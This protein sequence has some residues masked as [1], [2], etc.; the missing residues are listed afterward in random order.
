MI[1]SIILGL[2]TLVAI[3]IFVNRVWQLWLLLNLGQGTLPTNHLSERIKSVMINV[4]GQKSVVK[5]KSG[6]GHFFIFWGFIIVTFG[7]IE[8]FIAGF[9]PGFTFAFLGPVYPFMNFAQD[10]MAFTVL[11]AIAV[12]LYRRIVIQ[13]MRLEAPPAHKR[14]A[15]II[16]GMIALLLIC[17]YGMRIIDQTKPGFMPVASFLRSLVG[18]TLD[19][20]YPVFDWLHNLTVL[21]FLAFVPYSKHLH[22]LGA[23]PNIFF[24][25]NGKPSR[26]AKLDL[27]GENSESFGIGKISDYTKKDLLDLYAC[28]ECGR[29]QESCPAYFTAKPLSP[30]EV[31]QDLKAHLVTD[32]PALIKDPK[33]E[34]KTKLFANVITHDVLWACTTCRACE[35]VCPVFISPMGKLIGIRQNR[36]LMEGDF[37]EEAQVAMKNMENQSNPWGLP[38]DDRAKWAEGLPVKTLAEKADVEYLYYVGCSGAYDERNIQV[39]KAVSGLL[40]RAGVSWAILGKEETCCGDSARRIGNEYLFQ[41]L[42]TQ[43]VETFNRNNVRKVITTCPHCFNTI[44]NEFPEFGGVYQVLHHSELLS[45]LVASGKLPAA[46]AENVEVAYHDSCY[47]GRHNGVFDAPRKALVGAGVKVK[48]LE[49]NREKSFCCGA[50]GGRMWMEEKIGTRINEERAKEAVATGAKTVGTA[51][52]FCMTMMTDGMKSLGKSDTVKVKD[53]AEVLWES[54]QKLPA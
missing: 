12:A 19:P 29:C 15:F 41:T 45:D 44:K 8:G 10:I 54:V 16:L 27:S 49:R 37:P 40:N 48:E 9:F 13:P 43:S 31:I 46:P 23:G 14:E 25:E 5:E 30:K 51:C 18:G 11:A 42:A 3:G 7:T 6:I 21:G 22:I 39:T 36:V 2:C 28:T 34:T 32:G 53:V 52:P 17:F 26:I 38:Q 50:G 35:E 20:L 47:L 1:S 24:S 4:F 33:A